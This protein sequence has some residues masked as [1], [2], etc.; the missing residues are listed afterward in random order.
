MYDRRTTPDCRSKRRFYTAINLLFSRITH[1]AVVILVGCFLTRPAVRPAFAQVLD[2]G[3]TRVQVEDRTYLSYTSEVLD[4]LNDFGTDTYGTPHP[5]IF[6][7]VLDVRT[8]QVAA[9]PFGDTNWRADGRY[10]RRSPNGANFLQTQPLL[11]TMYR[12]SDITGDSTYSDRADTNIDYMTN[13]MVD[14]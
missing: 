4:N 13:N 5:E 11:R 8:K 2:S 10:D 14:S 12:L 1:S 3:I 9:P 6:V 7:S